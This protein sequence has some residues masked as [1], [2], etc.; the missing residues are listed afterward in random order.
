MEWIDTVIGALSGGALVSLFTLP[1]VVKKARSE[2]RSADLDNLQKA[3]EGW[4]QLADERQEYNRDLEE[5]IAANERR[6]DEL[7]KRIDELYS[8][9]ADWRDRFH[10]QQEENTSLKIKLTA[11]EPK[12]CLKRNCADREPQSGY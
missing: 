6:I 7:N 2:A 4:R 5:K 11:D 9:N 10:A 1:S 12:L 8:I 3:V